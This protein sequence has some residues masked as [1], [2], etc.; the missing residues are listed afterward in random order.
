MN[1]AEGKE[2][3]WVDVASF[4]PKS[5]MNATAILRLLAE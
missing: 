1:P 3:E 4:V 5:V 2:Q